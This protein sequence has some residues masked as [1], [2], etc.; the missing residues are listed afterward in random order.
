[1]WTIDNG[2]LAELTELGLPRRG[3]VDAALAT[4]T[5]D[6]PATIIYTSGTTGR[7]KGCVLTH[8]NLVFETASV[9]EAEPSVV[10]EHTTSVL[11]LPLAH[12]FARVLQMVL[13]ATRARIGY[14]GDASALTRAMQMM[15]PSLVVAV[16]RVF[17]K[18]IN[19]ATQRATADG[20][21][22]AFAKALTVAQKYSEGRDSG[23]IG[24][25]LRLQH[26]LFSRLVY[27]KIH[28]T[29][30]GSLKWAV[31]GG[32]PLGERLG[33]A[34]RGLGITILEGYGLTETTAGAS[35]NR[36]QYHPGPAMKVG[37]VGRP[38]PGTSARIAA[39][40]EVQLLGPNIFKG[41]WNNPDATRDTFTQDG[42]FRTGDLVSRDA[43]GYY[44]FR[45]RL[46]EIIIRGGS[47]I[48]PQEVE[49]AL[50]S[51]PAVHEAA[52]VGVPHAVWGEVVAAVVAVRE[53][54]TVSEG[55]LRTHVKQTLADYKVPEHI[56]FLPVL[57]KGPTGK[58]Q[59]RAIK[60]TLLQH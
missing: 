42:W 50:Y 55:E 38:V 46:K 49:D 13:V 18:L 28:A 5:P 34:F 27:S 19:T 44:W 21:G 45:G 41:Y 25:G 52:V 43:D 26:A 54:M 57:P 37:S 48:S 9:L 16:P 24:L 11:F 53:G 36:P 39:D 30:G 51:H 6:E 8:A 56:H 4:R 60:E 47:N 15:H 32:A 58:V 3:D 29:L 59:R 23:H 1:M 20:R 31:S 40:G 35:I 12:V 7:P 17:E 33:H 2:A 22:A 14:C 10:N